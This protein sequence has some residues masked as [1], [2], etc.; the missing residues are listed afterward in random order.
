MSAVADFMV[1]SVDAAQCTVGEKDCPRAMCPREAGL[2][3]C[4]EHSPRDADHAACTAYPPHA[5]H[6]VYPAASG[7]EHAVREQIL[8]G[9]LLPMD[10]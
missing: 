3:P 5:R 7:A 2:L 8:H 10:V 1:L 4:V 6:A 9:I